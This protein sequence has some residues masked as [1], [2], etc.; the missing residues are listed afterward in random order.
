M[1]EVLAFVVAL[2][3]TGRRREW[4][5]R[6]GARRLGRWGQLAYLVVQRVA[7]THLGDVV[8][9]VKVVAINERCLK[10]LCKLHSH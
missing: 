10:L 8:G 6:A 7:P 5:E 9:R 4:Q 3:G 2:E 1:V